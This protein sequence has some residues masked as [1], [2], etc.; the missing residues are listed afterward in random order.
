MA[1]AP[2]VPPTG[3]A[4]PVAAPGGARL[5]TLTID[6]TQVT[7]PQGTTIWDAARLAGIE[8]PVL[9]H[10]P[11]LRPVGVCRMC[12]VDVGER[13]L[14]ASCIRQC[15]P[16]QKVTT[17]SPKVV[18]HRRMLTQFL[19]SDYPERSVR[20]R[21][22]GTD[23]LLNLAQTLEVGDIPFPDGTRAEKAR[24]EDNSSPVIAVNHQACILCD[25]CIRA[26]DELQN[27]DVIGRTRRG[28]EARISFDLNNPMGDSTCVSCG[29]CMAV[30]P[31]G[32]LTNK[33]WA[34]LARQ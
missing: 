28:Y 24:G 9:C 21:A 18:G 26:C 17:N 12:V 3:A 6:G 29:E 23:E 2:A 10:S 30:C 1:D 13:V 32:A 27:N 7:V 5:V 34:P 16:D 19:L 15:S 22:L 8:I 31:T 14:A 33:S 4:P 25:R 20:D 11:R